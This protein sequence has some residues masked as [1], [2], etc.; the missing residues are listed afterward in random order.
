MVYLS[1]V[2]SIGHSLNDNHAVARREKKKQ[3][4]RRRVVL[5]D[6]LSNHELFCT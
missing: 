6:F 5:E 3:T 4:D 1:F 2:G